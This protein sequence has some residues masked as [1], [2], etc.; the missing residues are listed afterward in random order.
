MGYDLGL[1]IHSGKRDID[2][3]VEHYVHI[4]LPLTVGEQRDACRKG[5]LSTLGT[6]ALYHLLREF[7]EC[8]VRTKLWN[9][10]CI[11]FALSVVGHGRL[12]L[13]AE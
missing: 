12:D 11:G 8:E 6:Q 2:L 13:L 7:G 10:P 4:D 9:V 3:P 5:L 1:T